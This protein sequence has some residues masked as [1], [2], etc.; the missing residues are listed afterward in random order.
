MFLNILQQGGR[1]PQQRIVWPRMSV[2]PK[3]GF[4]VPILY[5]LPKPL[6]V[7]GP[8]LDTGDPEVIQGP[9]LVLRDPRF[10][11]GDRQGPSMVLTPRA[12][13]LS[14]ELG[15]WIRD[16]EEGT[17]SAGSEQ[18]GKLG[19]AVSPLWASGSSSGQC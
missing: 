10:S 1:A 13:E 19:Q 9:I 18:P 4:G 7:V 2:T 11:V 14:Q 6:T 15:G 8:G 12:R 17:R 5:F 3:K 16:V